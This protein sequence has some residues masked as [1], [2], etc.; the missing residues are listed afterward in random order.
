M[1]EKYAKISIDDI[2][3][4]FRAK[5]FNIYLKLGNAKFVKIINADDEGFEDTLE[6]YH[7]RGV[8]FLYCE[9]E[10]YDEV[11][12]SI[13]GKVDSGLEL[14][15]ISES[16]EERYQGLDD[17]LKGIKGMI[18]NLGIT[19]G[20]QKK[21][22]SLI[23]L[24]LEES[25]KNTRLEILLEI[26]EQKKGFI[27]KQGFLTSYIV[28][29]MVEEMDW[30]TSAVKRKL[31]TAS[32]FQNIALETDDQAKIYNL[33]SPEY[34][35]L[36]DFSKELVTKHPNLGADL[37]QAPGFGGEEVQ[38]LIKN[39]HEIPIAGGFPG[40]ISAHN[41][42]ILDACF[43]LAGYYSTLVLIKEENKEDYTITAQTLNEEFSI[44]GFK[45]AF[46]ALLKA[47]SNK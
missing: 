1:Q 11:L 44:G 27:S 24:T 31:V 20:V 26:L 5:P 30:A 37:V 12:S 4:F 14:A 8:N 17:A 29:S 36:D 39:H 43:I 45:R 42:P 23:N 18:H 32:L 6:D 16:L 15:S 2:P 7:S 13:E 19:E 40:R 46:T 47:V 34:S 38:K 9:S 21:A 33:N 35:E 10:V 28:I 3:E 22:D 41:V 25:E